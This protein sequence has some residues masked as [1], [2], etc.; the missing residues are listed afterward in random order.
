MS[1]EKKEKGD[2]RACADTARAFFMPARLCQAKQ[3]TIQV[4]G[5][6]YKMRNGYICQ[7]KIFQNTSKDVCRTTVGMN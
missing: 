4:L 5:C 7:K 2:N 1:K 6:V 3:N